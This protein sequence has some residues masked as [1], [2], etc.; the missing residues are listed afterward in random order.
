V[1]EMMND[2]QVV[3]MVR[4]SWKAEIERAVDRVKGPKRTELDQWFRREW[5]REAAVS[6]W[7]E[8]KQKHYREWRRTNSREAR[9]KQLTAEEK[10]WREIKEQKRNRVAWVDKAIKGF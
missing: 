5:Y 8:W 6:Q 10:A 7:P 1:I 2:M 4:E 3:R 9:S